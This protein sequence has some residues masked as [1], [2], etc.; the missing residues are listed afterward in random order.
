MNSNY[1]TFRK[2]LSRLVVCCFVTML[3]SSVFVAESHAQARVFDVNGEEITSIQNGAQ[4]VAVVDSLALV[5]FYESMKGDTWLINTGWLV[6]QVAFWYGVDRID[7]IELPNG[8]TEFRVTRME[9]FPNDNNMTQ[10]GFLP[11]E[12]SDLEY[13]ER[14][15]MGRQFVCGEIPPE[16]FDL[17]FLIRLRLR[18]SFLTGEI[19]WDAIGN[20]TSLERLELEQNELEGP[21]M[22]PAIANNTRLGRITL[23][24]NIRLTG[25]IPNEILQLEDLD[26]FG[27]DGLINIHGPM[28]DFSQLPNLEVLEIQFSN[29]DPGPFPAW[30]QNMG[31]ADGIERLALQETNIQG[32]V[33]SWLIELTNVEELKLGGTGMGMDMADFP[34]MSF[35]PALVRFRIWGGNFTGELPFWLGDMDLERLWISHTDIGGDLPGGIFQNLTSLTLL[36]LRHNQFTGGLPPQIQSISG[37]D[38]LAL[39]YNNMEIGN[40]PDWI[41]QNLTG[42]SKLYLGGSGVTGSIPS[43]L[44]NLES[45]SH[46]RLQD[47]P[48]LGGDL[49][50]WVWNLDLQALDLSYTNVNVGSSIPSELQNH[51]RMQKLGLAGLGLSGEIPSWLGD[52]PFQRTDG[53]RDWHP[54]L[55]LADNDLSGSI[56]M[57]MGSFLTLDSLNLANNNLTGDIAMFANIGSPNEGAYLLGAFDVSGNPG[58]T[59]EIPPNM[60]NFYRMR[61]FHFDGT[62]L[63]MPSGFDTFLE[64]VLENGGRSALTNRQMP[65]ASVTDPSTMEFCTTSIVD[66]PTDGNPYAFRLNH[67][68]P[69]PF[70]P[71]TNIQYQ[72]PDDME[73][74][75]TVYNM[76][77]QRVAT[78]VNERQSAGQYTVQFDASRLASGQYV[79]R[80]QAGDRTMSRSMTLIK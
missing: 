53:T 8:D 54:Y 59:G 43:S 31:G 11:P 32:E 28:P 14:L 26:R 3:C 7:E 63:C 69:N 18:G 19:P 79:Y 12:L 40:I 78:L 1:T 29:F 33:P 16:I 10:C 27:A 36:K 55:S 45:L 4:T 52:M 15:E 37:L 57:N 49:P 56:P 62:D 76:L 67:N 61:V 25:S 44:S 66:D 42:L 41:G 70:N 30:V 80:L 51:P 23:D 74:V 48:D 6:D 58:L 75:L 73:V 71:T 5:A 24:E 50:S 65:F 22:T 35:L 39:E 17:E 72:V 21:V 20:A 13:M 77:G 60:M 64:S 2:Y 38:Y 47:N 9:I 34:N 68:Y 46:I